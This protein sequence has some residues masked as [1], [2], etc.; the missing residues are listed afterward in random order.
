MEPPV[1]VCADAVA[2][3]V[4]AKTHAASETRIRKILLGKSS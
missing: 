1:A 4:H 2:A 3:I